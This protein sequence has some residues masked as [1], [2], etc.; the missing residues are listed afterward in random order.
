MSELTNAGDPAS[1]L[2]VTIPHPAR[3]YDYLLG[4]KDHFPADREAAENLVKFS[5]G[6]REGVRA[7]RAFLRRAVHYLAAEAGIE[8]IG[9]GI[10]TQ[11]NVHEIAQEVD[12]KARVV[13]ADNDPIVLVH[14]RALLTSNPAGMTTVIE[15]DLREPEKCGFQC[16]SPGFDD[17]RFCVAHQFI[18][19]IEHDRNA[20]PEQRF[21]VAFVQVTGTSDNEV[22]VGKIFF[23]FEH[24]VQHAFYFLHAASW[25]YSHYRTTAEGVVPDKRLP[26]FQ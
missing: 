3:I 1:R 5:P 10:P 19:L 13:Y 8:H 25:Q 22:V 18:G 26:V 11:G 20:V 15:A 17:A 6:T 24:D 16:G 14:G 7:H 23:Y 12:P 9:T 4:G 21:I 2:N